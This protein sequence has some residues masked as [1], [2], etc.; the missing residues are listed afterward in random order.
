MKIAVTYDNQ[1][2]EVFQHFGHT[3]YFKVY[4]L[5]GDQI[6]SSEVVSSEGFGHESLAD[7]L[8][9]EQIA[10]LICGGIGPGA[11]MA[12]AQMG[13]RLLAGTSGNADEV[14]KGILAGTVE[15]SETANCSHHHE[16]GGE[17]DCHHDHEEGHA[18]HCHDK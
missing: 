11:Q 15:Y 1:T 17:H 3:E 4:E 16:H 6:V 13:I 7:F 9:R 5:N 12:L 8:Y 18:C 2:G 10:A 14:V